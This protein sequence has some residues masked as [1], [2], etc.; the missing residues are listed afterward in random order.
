MNKMLFIAFYILYPFH[1]TIPS[2]LFYSIFSFFE[3]FSCSWS[4]LLISGLIHS[5]DVISH[6]RDCEG[7]S[8]RIG[9]R[10]AGQKEEAAR[11]SDRAAER[12]VEATRRALIAVDEASSPVIAFVECPRSL[13]TTGVTSL[14]AKI[15]RPWCRPPCP[16]CPPPLPPSPCPPATFSLCGS[17]SDLS[18]RSCRHHSSG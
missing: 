12:T 3:L 9:G 4:D 6:V 10:F 7:I 2:L 17:T 8:I 15:T 14:G 11:E 13:S 5:F 16:P 18:P 1:S